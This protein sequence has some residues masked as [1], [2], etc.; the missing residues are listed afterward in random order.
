MTRLRLNWVTQISVATLIVA[1]GSSGNNT[2]DGKNAANVGGQYGSTL[3]GNGGKGNSAGDAS[4]GGLSSNAGANA[5]GGNGSSSTAGDGNSQAG[6]SS[7]SGSS[8]STTA[9][10][11]DGYGGD[12]NIIGVGSSGS[13]TGGVGSIDIKLTGGSGNSTDIGSGGHG[14][15]I[16]VGTGG[17]F[18]VDRGSGGGESIDLGSGGGGTID[19]GTGGGGTIDL[20]TGGGGTIDLGTGGGSSIDHGCFVTTLGD[21][22]VYVIKDATPTGA[23]TEGKLYVGGNLTA[24]GYSVG[25]KVTNVDCSKNSLVV[26]GNAS[27]TGGMVRG[28]SAYYGG[29]SGTT[30]STGFDCPPGLQRGR[31]INF[32]NLEAE[33]TDLSLKLSQLPSTNCT[34]TV[35]GSNVT[36]T[37]TDKVF[38]VCSLDGSKLPVSAGGVSQ[39]AGV[40]VT[41]PAG[42][43]VAVNVSGTAINWA[44]A[45][46][47]LNGVS[48]DSAQ[49]NQVLWNLYQATSL[50]ASGIAIEGSVLAPLATLS[51]DGGHIAGQ[52][53]V[54]YLKGGLEYHPYMFSGCIKW[55]TSI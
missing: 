11:G 35:S 13:T 22:N 20:G 19:L 4:N 17:G 12:G 8:G 25:A 21:I 16:D 9:V 26:G 50:T 31:P 39:L 23:D 14:S 18:T 15:S 29:T 34:V 55:P 51:G 37:A 10:G 52:V 24:G 30:D 5:N 1:C 47:Y 41:F 46:V 43:S 44:G 45:A 27:L 42:S 54:K 7:G 28:G 38:S 32:A 36:I 40:N 49:A 3:G 48:S 33:V 2:V 6:N 53:I